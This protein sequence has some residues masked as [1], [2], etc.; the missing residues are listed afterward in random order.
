MHIIIID[1][2]KILSQKIEKK[3]IQEHYVTTLLHSYKEF[4]NMDIRNPDLFLIDISLW[5]GSWFDII[6]TLR[7]MASTK[8]IPI[9]LM[10]WHDEISTKVEGLDIWADDYIVKPFAPDE[11]LARIRSLLRRKHIPVENEHLHYK[12]F[13]FNVLTRSCIKDHSEISL[14][15]KE[16]QILEILLRNKNSLTKKIDFIEKLWWSSRSVVTDNTVNVTICN[17]RKKLWDDFELD[18]VSWEWYILKG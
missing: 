15:K 12:Q 7:S 9:L 14:T 17:L 10:S 2:E 8:N 16:K 18:T 3:L 1:D 5:D 4:E 6:K 13:T 11:L